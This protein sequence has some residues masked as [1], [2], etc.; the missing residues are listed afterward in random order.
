MIIKIKNDTEIKN[1]LHAYWWSTFI[2]NL[3][4]LPIVQAFTGTS[5]IE[6]ETR[7][8]SSRKNLIQFSR[9]FDKEQKLEIRYLNWD[10]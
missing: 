4:I 5:D 2:S 10:N 8:I 9:I 6:I 7:D 3:F 1:F